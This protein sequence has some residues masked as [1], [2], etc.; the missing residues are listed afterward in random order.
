MTLKKIPEDSEKS[1]K[2]FQMIQR[3]G[4]Y[5]WFRF[6]AAIVLRPRA[7]Y[8]IVG[9]AQRNGG[10]SIEVVIILFQDSSQDP[11]ACLLPTA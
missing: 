1:Q 9:G 7:G 10:G 5:D 8:A 3:Y 2:Q 11:S 4:Y 6:V